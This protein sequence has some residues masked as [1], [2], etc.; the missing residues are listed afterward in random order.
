MINYNN[1][2]AKI[3]KGKMIRLSLN[4]HEFI[5][6]FM[7][8]E[9]PEAK[10]FAGFLSMNKD[11]DLVLDSI[12]QMTSYE[13]SLIIQQSLMF[14]AIVTYAKC[15]TSN[16]GTRPSLDFNNIFRDADQSLK[17]E[18]NRIINLRNGY[19]A[20]AGDEFDHCHIVGTVVASGST[21]LGIDINCQLSHVVTM[22]PK[23]NDFKDL[24]LH[25]QKEI[26]L[27]SD[28]AFQKVFENTGN[29]EDSEIENLTY[30]FDKDELYA[31]VESEDATPSGSVRYGFVKTKIKHYGI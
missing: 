20:H 11:L 8:I 4:E 19:I 1:L 30:K 28:K 31:M 17:N 25:V 6:D 27:K 5:R 15:F 2:F 29:L 3:D 14:F 22:T 10:R 7:L 13:H 18:H 26:K 24:C 16:D 23:L 21:T 12:N 9:T